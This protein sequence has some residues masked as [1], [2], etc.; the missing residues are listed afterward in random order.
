MFS[1]PLIE[2]FLNRILIKIQLNRS[3][4]TPL[5]FCFCFPFR[6]FLFLFCYHSPLFFHPL[7]TRPPVLFLDWFGGHHRRRPERFFAKKRG[8]KKE[9]HPLVGEGWLRQIGGHL[10]PGQ[11]GFV[12]STKLPPIPINIHVYN[13]M[14]IKL[15][16]NVIA[17]N[18]SHFSLNIVFYY[19]WKWN[20]FIC[21][22]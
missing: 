13:T 12:S 16:R 9:T 17:V 2:L 15:I 18:V 19:K 4:V 14:T 6:G 22:F 8:I 10:C 1:S 11:R 20:F 5:F 21:L 3:S 7:V